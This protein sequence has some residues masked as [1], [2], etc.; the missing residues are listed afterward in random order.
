MPNLQRGY[1]VPLFIVIALLLL[2]IPA[3]YWLRINNLNFSS[4][5]ENVRGV[6]SIGTPYHKPGFSVSVSTD[7]ETWDLVEYLCNTREECLES[8][9]SGRRL[10]TVSGGPTE[11]HEVFVEYMPSWNDY[12]YIKY[13]VR[14]GWYATQKNFRIA[15]LGDVPGA[16]KETITDGGVTYEVVLA[17]VPDLKDAFFVS[18]HFTD[19]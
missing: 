17:P 7:V 4:S 6:K 19:R 14:S 11:L 10:G 5:G 1:S 16:T 13:Y 2:T 15:K 18:A 8:I 3:Y 9:S 12:S